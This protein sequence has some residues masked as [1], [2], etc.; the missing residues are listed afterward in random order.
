MAQQLL[1]QYVDD[2]DGTVADTVETVSFSVD[3]VSYE[4]DLNETNS[5]ALRRTLGTY[6]AKAR[7]TGGRAK[8]SSGG[9]ARVRSRAETEAIRNWARANG[10]QISDRGRIP[11]SVISAYTAAN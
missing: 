11:A 7:R 8:T 6:I 1:V 2:I 5:A 3:G 9:S 4:I 10:H